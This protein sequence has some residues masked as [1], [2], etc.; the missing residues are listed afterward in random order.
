MIRD[1]WTWIS[2]GFWSWVLYE[3][4]TNWMFFVDSNIPMI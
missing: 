4:F 1:K 2:I 3:G